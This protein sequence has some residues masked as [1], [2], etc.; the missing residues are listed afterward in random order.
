MCASTRSQI[1][2][3][4]GRENRLVGHQLAIRYGGRMEDQTHHSELFPSSIRKVVKVEREKRKARP[5]ASQVR[6][7]RG[8]SGEVTEAARRHNHISYHRMRIGA[9]HPSSFHWV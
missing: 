7:G 6:V 4:V 5:R 8:Q 9:P 2:D 3:E 1:E